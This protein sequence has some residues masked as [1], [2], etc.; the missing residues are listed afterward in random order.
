MKSIEFGDLPKRFDI[1]ER[2]AHWRKRWSELGIE[3]RDPDAPRESSFVIDS[4]P[5]TVSGSLH[6]GHAYSYTHQKH[7]RI[8]IDEG[9]AS[10]LLQV[11]L[12]HMYFGCLPEYV[13]KITRQ[14]RHIVLAMESACV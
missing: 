13:A 12:Y 4:P 7:K 14:H 9:D 2:E 11:C 8:C 3:K 1:N 10:S 6:A 5:L